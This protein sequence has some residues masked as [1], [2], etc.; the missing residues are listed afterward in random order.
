MSIKRTVLTVKLALFLLIPTTPAFSFTE[1]FAQFL[2]TSYANLDFTGKEQGVDSSYGGKSSPSDAVIKRPVILVHGSTDR[3]LGGHSGSW[4]K[5]IEA[6]TAHGYREAEIYALTWGNGQQNSGPSNNHREAYI[7]LVRTFIEAVLAYTGAEQVDL[8]AHS[9]GVTLS[10]GAIKGITSTRGAALPALTN[11][12]K[13]FIAIAGGNLGVGACL[14]PFADLM[15]TCSKQIGFHPESAYLSAL[16]NSSIRDAGQIY[17]FWSPKDDVI[18]QQV[19]GR[20]NPVPPA[21]T[22]RLPGENQNYSFADYSHLELRDRTVLQQI[23]L[24]SDAD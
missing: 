21:V 2:A 23:E 15:P 3:A 16:K 1:D 11:N 13:T 7:A 22:S 6:L 20:T 19:F 12:I 9:M 17:T 8:V 18:G 5:T 10:R 4:T 14:N 24:L